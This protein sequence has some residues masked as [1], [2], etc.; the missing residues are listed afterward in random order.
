MTEFVDKLWNK[1]YEKLV[2][3]KRKHFHCV[4]PCKYKEDASLGRWVDNQ[5]HFHSKNIIRLDR[6]VLLDELGFVWSVAKSAQW[7]KQYG[8]LVEFKRK[9]GNCL[10]SRKYQEDM[11]LGKWVDTQRQF[12]CKNKMRQDRKELLEKI[13]FVWKVGR[14]STT[15]VSYR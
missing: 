11:S 6:K 15:D 12:H 7:N 3:F 5:R 10:V 1:Q 4:V 2:E 13:G 8:K 14:S 9:H